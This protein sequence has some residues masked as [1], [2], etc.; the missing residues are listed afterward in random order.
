[1]SSPRHPKPA[2]LFMGLFLN[3]KSLLNSVI[4]ELTGKFGEVDIISSWAD[5]SYTTYYESEMGKNLKR[6]VIIFKSLINQTELAE[7]KIFT[8]EIEDRFSK[9]GKR[10]VNIDP[11]YL[12]MERFVL[13]SCKNFTHKIYL[14][15]GI[16][17]DLTLIYQ[18]GGFKILPW[19]F[20]EYAGKKMILFLEKVRKKYA[21]DLEEIIKQ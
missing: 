4:A 6:R 15:K 3:E 17:A 5:F 16:Y 20:P 8:N 19:T 7:I 14:D 13:A 12:L 11:G 18:G 1:M 9:K 2:K 21:L 10:N